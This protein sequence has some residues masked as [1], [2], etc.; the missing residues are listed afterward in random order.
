MTSVKFEFIQVKESN[1]PLVNLEKYNFILEPSYFNQKL[2]SD[3]KIFLRKSVAEKLNRIQNKLK[4]YKF[5]IWD[6]YRSREVQN[7]IYKKFWHELRNKNPGWNE[8]KLDQE[9]SVF[10]TNPNDQ[11]RIPPHA[12]GG[13][14]DL[15]LVDENNIELNMGTSFDY[16]G[17]ES[18]SLYFENNNLNKQIKNNRKLLR[19]AMLEEEFRMDEDEWWHFDYGNQIWAV[20]QNKPFAIYGEVKNTQA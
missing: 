8:K 16:F 11:K 2:S 9:V 13:A 17:K 19:K 6:G 7:N 4:K 3:K 1:E 5:K 14:V 20:K 10:V 15:T 18:A 12:T